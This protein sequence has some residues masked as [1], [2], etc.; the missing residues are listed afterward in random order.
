VSPTDKQEER[1]GGDERAPQ[2]K[3]KVGKVYEDEEEDYFNAP[4]V[5]TV[6]FSYILSLHFCPCTHVC[7]NV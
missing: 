7:H 4:E 1:G 5:S 3:Q 6:L 2:G